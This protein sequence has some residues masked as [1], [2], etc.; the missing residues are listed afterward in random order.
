MLHADIKPPLCYFFT[1]C[2]YLYC[3]GIV[4]R[5]TRCLFAKFSKVVNKIME[6]TL[7]NFI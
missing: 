6:Y 4:C 5:Q 2:W 7:E 3:V 1:I